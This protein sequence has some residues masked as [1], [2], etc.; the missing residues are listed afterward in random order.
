LLVLAAACRRPV[1]A[2]PASTTVVREARPPAEPERCMQAWQKYVEYLTS[3]GISEFGRATEHA[4]LA[5]GAFCFYS[6][7]ADDD[8]EALRAAASPAGVVASGLR[9]GDA[10]RDFLSAADAATLAARIAWLETRAPNDLAAL[11]LVARLMPDSE[12]PV[13]LDPAHAALVQV[14]VLEKL[15]D[16]SLSLVAWFLV[17]GKR[18]PERWHIGVPAEGDASI[19][20]TPATALVAADDDVAARA[21]AS[22]ASAS[23]RE[24]LWALRVVGE[25]GLTQALPRAV[26]LLEDASDDVRA[27]AAMTLGELADARVLPSVEQ[28]FVRERDAGL[29]GF[30]VE[31]L[32]AFPDAA[33]SPV[34]ARLVVTEPDVSVRLKIV[35]ALAGRSSPDAREALAERAARDPDAAVRAAARSYASDR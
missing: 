28:A 23:V 20:R 13:A 5:A 11:R 16:G 12:A 32:A 3:E 33:G 6:Y 18:A 31:A 1:K 4:S 26:E 14:P 10:W 25:H 30:F 29:R 21:L 35:H 19:E 15:A 34:L 7:R 24:R 2:V 27:A 17:S 8:R 22:L 9:P